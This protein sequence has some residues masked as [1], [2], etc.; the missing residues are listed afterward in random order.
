MNHIFLFIQHPD[1][2][3]MYLVK[4]DAADMVMHAAKNAYPKEFIGLLGSRME[5][6]IIDELILIPAVYGENSSFIYS[7]YKPIERNIIGSVHSHPCPSNSPSAE[8]IHSFPKFGKIHLIIAYPFN[9]NNIK[10]FDNKG[11]EIKF[12]VVE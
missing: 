10:M 1:L 7:E 5:N 9:I 2:I 6:N 12:K 8:D 4:K 11:K 3:V